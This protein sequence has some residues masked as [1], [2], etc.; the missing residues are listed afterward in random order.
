[1]EW[2]GRFADMLEALEARSGE[3]GVTHYA[4]SMPTLEEVFLRCTAESHQRDGN[5]SAADSA[6]ADGRCEITLTPQTKQ[7]QSSTSPD[8]AG[9]LAAG[10]SGQAGLTQSPASS[11]GSGAGVE[12]GGSRPASSNGGEAGAAEEAEGPSA[13]L[14]I[15]R[16]DSAE[17]LSSVL[18]AGEEADADQPSAKTPERSSQVVGTSRQRNQDTPLTGTAEDAVGKVEDAGASAVRTTADCA[19]AGVSVN[20]TGEVHCIEEVLEEVP[21]HDPAPKQRGRRAR[22]CVAFREMLRKRAIIA[23]K[24]ANASC[25]LLLLQTPWVPL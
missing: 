10:N 12:A 2:R 25:P 9:S 6:A 8:S 18:T 19:A 20:G 14:P 23:G 3:L 24:I 21:L 7:P 17:A 16:D 5:P 4:V 15:S 1:M 22:A 13:P 11:D